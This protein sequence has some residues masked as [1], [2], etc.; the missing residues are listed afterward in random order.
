M[1]KWALGLS[2]LVL[3]WAFSQWSSERL[4]PKPDILGL[5]THQ[6]WL[7]AN[8]NIINSKAETI[9]SSYVYVFSSEGTFKVNGYRKKKETATICSGYWSLEQNNLFLFFMEGNVLQYTV[10]SI[11]HQE[12]IT[13]IKGCVNKSG[14]NTCR[15]LFIALA[16][17]K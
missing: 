4:H 8:K 11:T 13:E 2:L 16:S 15:Q 17:L 9:N 3:A 1:K 14:I 5:L 10:S 12:L 6:K 7:L